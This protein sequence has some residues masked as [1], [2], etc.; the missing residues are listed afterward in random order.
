MVNDFFYLCFFVKKEAK[1][2]RALS[3][4]DFQ[5]SEP[6]LNNENEEAIQFCLSNLHNL[7]KVR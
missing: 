2:Q 4:F 3:R 6:H 7:S 5:E 1:G